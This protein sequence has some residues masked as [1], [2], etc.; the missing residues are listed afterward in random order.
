[1]SRTLNDKQP[2]T[3]TVLEEKESN[4]NKNAHKF[5]L[6]HKLGTNTD[7]FQLLFS[8]CEKQAPAMRKAEINTTATLTNLSA[9]HS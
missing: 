3:R 8:V 1:V 2:V 5:I 9:I 4:L 7:T 6:L